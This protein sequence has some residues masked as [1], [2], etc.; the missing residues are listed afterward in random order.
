MIYIILY[1]IILY[2]IILYYIILYY[3]I[4]YYIILYYIILYYIIL[5]SIQLHV[6][7]YIDAIIRLHI[8]HKNEK[9]N[10]CKRLPKY[11]HIYLIL[12]FN[13]L[14]SNTKTHKHCKR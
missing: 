4:L 12:Q 6:P 14:Y 2:Y 10:N 8:Q 9:F 7:A 11:I 3:I 13:S 1:Y 5:S